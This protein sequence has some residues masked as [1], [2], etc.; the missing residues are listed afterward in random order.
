MLFKYLGVIIWS[1]FYIQNKYN[2]NYDDINYHY[3]GIQC[4]SFTACR[5]WK[6]L[7]VKI[8]KQECSIQRNQWM[9]AC[10]QVDLVQEYIKQKLILQ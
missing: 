7:T 8:M 9:Q 1:E 10:R 5:N 2:P 4:A 3:G 6:C